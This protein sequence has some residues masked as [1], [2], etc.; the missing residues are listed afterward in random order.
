MSAKGFPTSG[1]L[2]SAATCCMTQPRQA[3]AAS[4]LRSLMGKAGGQGGLEASWLGRFCLPNFI[5][6]PF[7][8]H[9]SGNSH[10]TMGHSRARLRPCPPC[11]AGCERSAVWSLTSLAALPRRGQHLH[12]HCQVSLQPSSSPLILDLVLRI[13]MEQE[14]GSSRERERFLPRIPLACPTVTRSPIR[15]SS[16]SQSSFRAPPLRESNFD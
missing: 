2:C 7:S 13:L 8:S 4:R 15:R 12:V 9:P 10:H 16:R 11:L 6:S 14:R 3:A 5:H 1:Q